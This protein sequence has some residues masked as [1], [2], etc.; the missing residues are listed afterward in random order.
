MGEPPAALRTGGSREILPAGVNPSAGGSERTTTHCMEGN[1][2]T[3]GGARL[4]SESLIFGE[5]GRRVEIKKR[6]YGQMTPRRKR[7]RY[8]VNA[9]RIAK[10]LGIDIAPDDWE[11]IWALLDEHG[12]PRYVYAIIDPSTNLVKFGQSKNP[13]GRIK[14]LRTGNA[15]ELQMRAYCVEQLPLTERAIHK[16]LARHRRS[17]EWFEMG[18]E[19]LRVIR[20]MEALAINREARRRRWS[21]A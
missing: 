3:R 6:H 12:E 20:E 11:A 15:A 2:V 4:P 1:R 8:L 7:H 13:R 18:S 5:G 17:G 10:G 16:R 19:T 9:Q 14:A 21:S